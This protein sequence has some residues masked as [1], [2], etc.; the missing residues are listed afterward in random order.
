[1]EAV[2]ILGACRTAIGSFGGSLS[3]IPA[4]T[5]GETVIKEALKRAGVPP[6]IVDEV[7]LGNVLQA[8][9]GQNTAR[10]A[11][12]GAGL[13]VEIPAMTINKVCGSGL[14]ALNL[15]A[16]AIK[17]G[18]ANC[19][20]AGGMENMS[21]SPYLLKDHR[22]G[23]K[24]GNGEFIDEMICDGLWDNFNGYH[25]GITA[26]NL[27]EKYGITRMEQDE[28]SYASQMKAAK[29]TS[30]GRFEDEIVSVVVPQKKGDAV[31]FQKDEY[32]RPDISLEKLAKLKPSFKKDGTVTAGNSSGIN[33]GAAAMIL[34]SGRL[35][36]RYGLKPMAKL[37]SYGSKGVSPE[38][39]GIGPVPSV[40]EAL[41][42]AGLELYDITLIEANE[43]FAAQ[44]LAVSKELGFVNERVNVNGGAIAMGHP[45][46]A[47]GAR[48]MVTL[49]HEMAKRGERYGLATLCIGGG[50]GEAT[51]VERD[52]LCE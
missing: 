18:E 28:F 17:S 43:A 1:M 27:A 51:I 4:V 25:M 21:Q 9:L 46:G 40:K 32:I 15:A 6:E 16:Q 29:A 37:L 41:N 7:I 20:I 10:Q 38:I 49:L 26:E 24:M 19:V 50:M 47:S 30:E 33:D 36:A 23:S 34:A 22:W 12:I 3:G 14:K 45:I 48:I 39:M 11:A 2:Y 35:V 52:R 13:P 44:S 31:A 42:R 8:G 5:L